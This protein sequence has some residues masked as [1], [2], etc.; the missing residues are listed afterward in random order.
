MSIE[1]I[2]RSVTVRCDPERAFRL[3]TEE[4]GS[5]WPVRTHARAVTEFEDEDLKVE[6]VEFQTFE[7]G[8]VLEHMSNGE[9]LPWGE[10]V[11]WD[12]PRSFVLAWKPHPR[13][14]PP[15]E[16]EVRFTAQGQHTIVE[17]E[18]RAWERLGE[19]VEEIRAG[20]SEGWI[21]TLER[22]RARADELAA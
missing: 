18:H 13:P 20:Y 7:G 9:T 4:M 8:S 21:V 3:F 1:S 19:D 15:T 11:A 2:L 10:V 22:F 12:P 17:L 14:T 6:R 5:W 16:V